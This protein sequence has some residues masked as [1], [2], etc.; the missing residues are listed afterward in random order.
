MQ[1]I[2]CIVA[3]ISLALGF[4]QSFRPGAKDKV[5]W[6]EGVAI[7][8]AVLVI[9]VVQAL[10]DY[11]KERQFQSLYET[12]IPLRSRTND[13]ARKSRRQTDKIGEND[14]NKYLPCCGRRYYASGDRRYCTSGWGSP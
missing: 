1:I 14:A 2:L 3:I 7:L 11:Q 4:Y 10:N 8:V 9:T 5:E 6:V 13:A 12:V